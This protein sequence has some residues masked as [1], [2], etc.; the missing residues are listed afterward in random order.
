MGDSLKAEGDKPIISELQVRML[1]T[2]DDAPEGVGEK[3]VWPW[4]PGPKDE[5]N[6]QPSDEVQTTYYDEKSRIINPNN[7]AES[8]NSIL[9]KSTK[10]KGM[11]TDEIAN[12]C[13]LGME[14][15]DPACKFYL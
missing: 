13:V 3:G 11:Y 7:I 12:A 9:L 5:V 8:V 14:L 1:Y 10:Y 4:L 6:E 2:T 15:S